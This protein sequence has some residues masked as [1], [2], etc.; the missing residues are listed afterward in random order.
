MFTRA[1][2]AAYQ[3]ALM[4][5]KS[6]KGPTVSKAASRGTRM[7]VEE[8]LQI[9]NVKRSDVNAQ[10]AGKLREVYQKMFTANDPKGGGSFYLQ[11][12]VYRAREVLEEEF[13]IIISAR[14]GQAY[15]QANDPGT[16]FDGND[17]DDD[18]GWHADHHYDKAHRQATESQDRENSESDVEFVWVERWDKRHHRK[19]YFNT[20]TK[21]SQWEKPDD[22]G[23]I[24]LD[25]EVEAVESNDGDTDVESDTE[26]DSD[27]D[28]GTSDD[29]LDYDDG[30]DDG[31]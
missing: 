17:H 12:K 18:G 23:F 10:N 21:Q 2:V 13:N 20:E 31:D 4:N 6:G 25:A 9:L 7:A 19:Y 30:G 3:Q 28:G 29:A 27:N 24:P 22:A 8:A 26:N 1:F 15:L 16:W 14:R 11:S 5:A